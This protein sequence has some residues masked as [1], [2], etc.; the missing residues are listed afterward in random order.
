MHKIR[1]ASQSDLSALAAMLAR[2]FNNDPFW[3][4]IVDGQG[5]YQS[6]LCGGFEAQL[7]HMALPGGL[8][9]CGG[10]HQ[11]AALW[12]APGQWQLGVLQQL[13]FLPEFVRMTPWQR[14]WKVSRA[15]QA[16]QEAHP[17]VPHYYLQVL[18]VDPSHQGKGWSRP[19]I[20]TGLALADRY[21]QPAYLET[22]EQSNLSLYRRYGFEV[23]KTLG[24]MP[25]NPPPLWCMWREPKGSA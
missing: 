16:V 11:G 21:A 1:P 2:A 15:I 4:W 17:K 22:A 6:R 23:T 7:R 24:D 12:S 13:R 18:G 19:L 10:Q 5:D 25:G 14:L 9:W 3:R 20:E 8:V